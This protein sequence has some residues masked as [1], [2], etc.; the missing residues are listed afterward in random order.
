MFGTRYVE[1][2][3]PCLDFSIRNDEEA[4]GGELREQGV[5]GFFVLARQ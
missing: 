2:T 4:L 1:S 3:Q 5:S